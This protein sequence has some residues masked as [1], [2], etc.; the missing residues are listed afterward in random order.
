MPVVRKIAIGASLAVVVVAAL[1][2]GGGAG[3]APRSSSL[4]SVT[5]IGSEFTSLDSR[6]YPQ[7]QPGTG[8]GIYA[9]APGDNPTMALF[10]ATPRV[11]IGAVI[12]QVTFYYR[13]CLPPDSMN[14]YFAVY[15]PAKGTGVLPLPLANMPE[16]DCDSSEMVVRQVNPGVAVVGSKSFRVGFG[17]KG[18]STEPIDTPATLIVGAKVR[19]S[20]PNGC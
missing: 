20:C 2:V 12:N 15:D 8:G 16:G 17:T 14:T 6:V 13:N 5:I 9:V 1:V 3:A 4:R 11:P 19:Y 10:E 7:Y 18:M